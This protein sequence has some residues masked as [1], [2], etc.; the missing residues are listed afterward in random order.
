MTNK[1]KIIIGIGIVVILTIFIVA[2]LLK[3]KGGHIEVQVSEVTRGDITQVVSG[4]GKVQPETKVK[5]SANVSAEIIGLYVKEGDNVRK[6]DLLVELDS[7]RYEAAE[8]QAASNLKSA[9]ARLKKARSEYNRIQ[10]LFKQNLVSVA[11]KESA[12]A[13]FMLAESNVEQAQARLKQAKD[14]LSKTRIFSPI[15]GTVTQL[16]KELG[17]I[18]VGSTFQAD[19]IMTV[20][21]LSRM[22]VLAEVDEND[23]V[24]VSLNDST[25]IEIDAIPDTTFRGVVSEIAHTA[26]TRGRGTQE[27]VTNFEVKIAVVDTV[28]QLRP[29][30]SATVDI[31]TE[32]HHNV[33]TVPIQ[34][35]TVRTPEE[36][37]TDDKKKS[38]T[39]EKAKKQKEKGKSDASKA[40]NNDTEKKLVEVVFVVD[41]ETAHV[42]PVKTG[43]SNDTDIEIVSGLKE[44]QS[45][46]TGSY[47]AISKTLKEG[48]LVKIN[49]GQKTD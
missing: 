11:E 4:T 20:A 48:S 13:E 17:E 32:N 14:D 26:T 27:E 8:E 39:K 30:M 7:K 12:E 46:V 35:V 2:N 21:D 19:V 42:V 1:K 31:R 5:I 33:L 18:A 24:L 49:K 6:G 41:G 22:E 16:N 37:K 38:D 15:D 9:Q 34:A 45:V 47:R 44:G 28:P 36:I 29:G 23:V 25:D 43:I 40:D 10:N 3:S